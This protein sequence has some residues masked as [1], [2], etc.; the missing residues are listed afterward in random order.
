MAVVNQDKCEHSTI[1]YY[2]EDPNFFR[3]GTTFV[4]MICEKCG[5]KFG[6]YFY[7]PSENDPSP[8]FKPIIEGTKMINEIL[9]KQHLKIDWGD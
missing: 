9:K 4:F 3:K 2:A 5:K 1:V 6:P 7:D 8:E